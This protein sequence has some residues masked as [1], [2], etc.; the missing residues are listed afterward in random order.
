MTVAAAGSG[1]A[2]VLTGLAGLFLLRVAGQ[3]LV[4][5]LD[6]DWLPPMTEWY[7]GLLPYPLLLP[8][9]G[10]I[11]ALQARVSWDLLRGRGPMAVRRPRLGRILQPLSLL[12]VAAMAARYGLTM[13]WYPERRW[14]G[15]GT[16]PIV[17]HWVLAAWLFTLA[18]Y[19][20]GRPGAG[21]R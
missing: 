4:A 18:R 17:F 14:L 1:H 13:A 6:V 3:A 11:L 10:L 21:R 7:S 19:H 8:A 2:V 12:Y 5:A 9:Q 15:T 16:I 20:L